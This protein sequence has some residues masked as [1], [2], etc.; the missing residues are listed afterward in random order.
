[1]RGEFEERLTELEERLGYRFHNLDLLKEALTH[2]SFSRSLHNERLE[3]LGDAVLELIIRSYLLEAFQERSE[4][5]L[6]KLKSALVREEC[7]ADQA[8]KLHLDRYLRV[9]KGEEIKRSMLAAAFEALIGAIYLDG[10]LSK[11]RELVMR[12]VGRRLWEVEGDEI[13]GDYKSALQERWQALA[14]SPPTYRVI[15]ESGPD[16]DKTFE[17]EVYLA[18]IPYGRGKGKSK[19]EAEQNAAR[20]ALE[21]LL[22]VEE[23]D[24]P[25][26]EV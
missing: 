23:G 17:V 8:L 20:A 10:G 24:V 9:G 22:A 11:A 14:K 6:S 13:K 21:K 19:K 3:F 4:G 1:M 2:K 26:E 15:S 25:A 12:T 16:H 5:E 7:L 18:G